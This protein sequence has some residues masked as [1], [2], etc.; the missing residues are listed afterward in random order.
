MRLEKSVSKM[1]GTKSKPEEQK[2][3]IVT[4]VGQTNEATTY[5]EELKFHASSTSIILSIILLLMLLLILYGIYKISY[6]CYKRSV[7]R[8]VDQHMMLRRSWR[9][10][11]RSE[12]VVQAQGKKL[13]DDLGV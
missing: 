8:E 12:R 1:G 10:Y 9:P 4:Q 5:I 6:R 2:E 13:Q 3:I 11:S 7:R